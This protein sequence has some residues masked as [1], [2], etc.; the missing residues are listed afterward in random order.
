MA[1][2]FI[3]EESPMSKDQLKRRV[4]PPK[5]RAPAKMGVIRPCSP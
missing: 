1:S 3:H 2:P 4:D 5:G